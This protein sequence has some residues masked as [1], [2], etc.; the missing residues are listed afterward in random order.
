MVYLISDIWNILPVNILL[1]RWPTS[2]WRS[3]SPVPALAAESPR[4]RG[5]WQRGSPP[6][7][8]PNWENQ[9]ST[10]V[11]TNKFCPFWEYVLNLLTLTS[12]HGRRWRRV[13]QEPCWVLRPIK[14]LPVELELSFWS[15]R[16][17]HSFLAFELQ[18]FLL[19]Q[20][21]FI[22]CYFVVERAYPGQTPKIVSWMP[23]LF[24]LHVN[25]VRWHKCE[26][27]SKI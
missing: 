17:Y 26:Q 21:F 6:C 20:K 4:W 23:R 14:Y 1:C 9:A 3:T 27:W 24:L 22:L 8:S 25:I 18:T 5:G 11:E 19:S 7:S 2:P 13:P 15:R 12:T 10:S 16:W